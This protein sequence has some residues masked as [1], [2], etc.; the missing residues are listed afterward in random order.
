MAEGPRDPHAHSHGRKTF[1]L[2]NLFVQISAEGQLEAPH[3]HGPR[4]Y[5]RVTVNFSSTHTQHNLC[6][7]I[8]IVHILTPPLSLL[9][10]GLSPPPKS[11][12]AAEL[13]MPAAAFSCPLCLKSLSSSW[14]VT[15]HMRTH[16]GEKPFQ[17]SFCGLRFSVKN[18]LKRHMM[19]VHRKN[20]VDDSAGLQGFGHH[21]NETI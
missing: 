11:P 8:A 3:E 18:N 16:T 20:A 21:P 5:A 2:P 1:Q 7:R 9:Q 13:H 12:T 15:R 10:M 6:K 4:H 19:C 14:H 17:C